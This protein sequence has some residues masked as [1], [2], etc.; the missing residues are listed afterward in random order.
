MNSFDAIIITCFI[1]SIIL[2][3]ITVYFICMSYKYLTESNDKPLIE[4]LNYQLYS[5]M[6]LI[7]GIITAIISTIYIYLTLSLCKRKILY[8]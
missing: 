7:S 1:L 8:E 4:M 3:S 2:I 6:Y 5:I